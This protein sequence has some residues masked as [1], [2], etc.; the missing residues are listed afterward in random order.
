[1]E[2]FWALIRSEEL[3]DLEARR[4]RK[5]RLLTRWGV[6]AL[7]QLLRPKYLMVVVVSP[8]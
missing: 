2:E 5:L 6:D 4:N 7:L 3:V 8:F 1:V